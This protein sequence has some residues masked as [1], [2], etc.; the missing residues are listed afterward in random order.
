MG[1]VG[2]VGF[3]GCGSMGSLLVRKLLQF[4][5]LEESQVMVSDL[6]HEKCEA[7]QRDWPGIAIAP[8]NNVLA[9]ASTTI[10]LC[11]EPGHLYQVLKDMLGS[12]KEGTHL[13]SV[14]MGVTLEDLGRVYQGKI[15]RII[16]GISLETGRGII[17][18]THNSSVL[19][20][21]TASIESMLSSLGHVKRIKESHFVSAAHLTAFSAALVAS[22]FQEFVQA[23]L[24]ANSDSFTK[25]DGE[26]IAIQS[27]NSIASII[28]EDRL[29]FQDVLDR[30]STK[31]GMTEEGVIILKRDLPSIF[32][33][34]I[35]RRS[36]KHD[37]INE[38]FKT[39]LG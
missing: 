29:E 13:I 19:S 22:V 10:F 30:V 39:L 37:E 5:A 27:L 2:N 26:E 18:V 15:T 21:D 6:Y 28:Y 16:P 11:V 31:G 36:L 14:A 34:V 25:A 17:P 8:D 35:N 20:D 33:E 9:K 24:R 23:V 7:I 4:Q 12:I 1:R 38:K 32:Q 3:V